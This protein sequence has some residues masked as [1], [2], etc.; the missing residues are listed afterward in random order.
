MTAKKTDSQYDRHIYY[1]F[2]IFID[3]VLHFLLDWTGIWDRP[4][5]NQTKKDQKGPFWKL[6]GCPLYFLTKK[7]TFFG[8]VIFATAP[9][10]YFKP[11]GIN[12]K[13]FKLYE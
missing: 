7:K 4:K 9:Y 13:W 6:V 8:L 12:R 2:S 10:I 1:A 3:I 11:V 5:S